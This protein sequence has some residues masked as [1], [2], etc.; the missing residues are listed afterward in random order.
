MTIT[1]GHGDYPGSNSSTLGFMPSKEITPL[2]L[3]RLKKLLFRN[4]QFHVEAMQRLWSK[5]TNLESFI[6]N[7]RRPDWDHHRTQDPTNVSKGHDARPQEILS[8]LEPT[9]RTLR[10][11][12][13]GLCFSHRTVD[14]MSPEYRSRVDGELIT[15]LKAFQLCNILRLTTAQSNEQDLK[16]SST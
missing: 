6:F 9:S 4:A 7:D 15:L 2:Q 12:C 14:I 5:T 3:P 16:C 11:L 8:A 13:I 10:R 1:W